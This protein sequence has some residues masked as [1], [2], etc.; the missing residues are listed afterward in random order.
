MTE[1][2]ALVTRPGYRLLVAG[3]R[4]QQGDEALKA[5]AVTWTPAPEWSVGLL[6]QPS[7]TQL[8]LPHRRPLTAGQPEA[9][10]GEVLPPCPEWISVHNSLPEPG[11]R[12]LGF[13]GEDVAFCQLGQFW[14]KG[15]PYRW[16]AENHG[17]DGD[18]G[19]FNCTHW[20]RILPTPTK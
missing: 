10:S 8:P 2:T 4:I 20:L 9:L 17:Y 15:H 19:K 3:D 6:Y 16:A 5:D 18:Y 1:H 14:G 7:E 11:L 13:D 12:V